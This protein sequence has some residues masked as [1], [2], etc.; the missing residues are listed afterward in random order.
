MI[1]LGIESTAHTFG[2]SIVEWDGK[3]ESSARILSNEK[4]SYTTKTG[5]II[6]AKLGDHH[7]DCSLEIVKK[8]IEK[9]EIKLKNIDLVS[10]SQG[11]GI[12]NALRIGSMTARTL[13]NNLNKPLVG[14]NHCIAHLE[15]VKI[16]VKPNKPVPKDPILL[17]VSGANTQVIAYEGKRYRI[18]GETLDN[19]V[20]NF[21]DSF[22]RELGLGFPGGPKIMKLAEKGKKYIELPY[23]VKGMDIS[24]GGILTNLK[25]K[26]KSGEYNKEDLC[27]SA[28]ETV[29][30]MLV[31]V[32]ERAL[33]H[34]GK[35]ELALG[36][37]VACNTRLQEMCRIMCEERG[38]KLFVPP[39]SLLVDN[40]AMIAWLGLLKYKAQ[41]KSDKDTIMRPHERTDYVEVTWR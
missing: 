25:H 2:A 33:A 10:F 26:I 35:D 12:G 40:A 20:G 38:A 7:T 15:I 1:C 16:A 27:Y 4:D 30:A 17:Y 18:F 19:G 24:V 37:G 9:A 31:E 41:K 21:L 11:P 3:K 6:P 8:A 22:A 32:A 36:G 5:G 28:Q 39:N 14:V 13:A 34:T 23:V 29:F